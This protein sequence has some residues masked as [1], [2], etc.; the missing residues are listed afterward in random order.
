MVHGIKNIVGPLHRGSGAD[1]SK[2]LIGAC[3][4]T[5]LITKHF[6]TILILDSQIQ[7]LYEKYFQNY[8]TLQAPA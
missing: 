2:K 1:L 8:Q 5:L 4:K 3:I 6:D 7:L